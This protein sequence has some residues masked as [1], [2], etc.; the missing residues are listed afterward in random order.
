[1][2]N[3]NARL[4]TSPVPLRTT[5][6]RRSALGLTMAGIGAGAVNVAGAGPAFAAE[7]R[8]LPTTAI[9][10][11]LI[12]N[13]YFAGFRADKTYCS[14]RMPGDP[15]S[16]IRSRVYGGA[17]YSADDL[18][19]LQP[20]C[21][22]N[23]V[24][25][26]DYL[27]VRR[28]WDNATIWTHSTDAHYQDDRRLDSHPPIWLGGGAEVERHRTRG[29]IY[30]RYYRSG[31][32]RIY[33]HWHDS[34]SNSYRTIDENY[35]TV[36]AQRFRSGFNNIRAG[37]QAAGIDLAGSALNLAW[38]ANIVAGS[39]AVGL[40]SGGAGVAVIAGMMLY[41]YYDAQRSW[42]EGARFMRLIWP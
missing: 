30:V 20:Y 7:V 6:S 9:D 29:A 41:R 1:M 8:G 36:N 21:E 16:T 26:S 13:P 4:S 12:H 5:I 11:G 27:E 31:E 37:N 39:A 17:W 28:G 40:V 42:D 24:K 32:E 10:V 25:Y 22:Y 23:S 2:V 3:F 19:R 14:F 38:A 35:W 33:G 15:A 34:R 18:K